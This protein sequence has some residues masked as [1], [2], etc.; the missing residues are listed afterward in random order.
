MKKCSAA[1]VCARGHMQ[2]YKLH[3]C[4]MESFNKT[5]N[6]IFIHLGVLFLL[7]QRTTLFGKSCKSS[8]YNAVCTDCQPCVL[9]NLKKL[10][11]TFC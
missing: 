3:C 4:H 11:Q 5:E 8:P 1:K 10:L 9:G 6:Q 7:F 2:P